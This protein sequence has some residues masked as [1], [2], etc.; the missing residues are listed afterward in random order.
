L[1]QQSPGYDIFGLKAILVFQLVR[2]I[3]RIR[4]LP[5]LN[6]TAPSLSPVENGSLSHMNQVGTKTAYIAVL[7]IKLSEVQHD[8]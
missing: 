8:L 1:N 7:Y 3:V 6:R 5:V 4:T 2:S